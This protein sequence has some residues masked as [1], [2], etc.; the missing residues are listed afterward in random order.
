M[1]AGLLI[2]LLQVDEIQRAAR[3]RLAGRATGS[4]LGLHADGVGDGAFSPQ[5]IRTFWQ[6]AVRDTCGELVTVFKIVS[7]RPDHDWPIPVRLPAFT[8][9]LL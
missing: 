3:D 4:E 2:Q 8:Q 9:V 7:Q 1:H 5:L 6:N